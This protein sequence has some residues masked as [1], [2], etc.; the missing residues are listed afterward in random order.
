L[1]ALHVDSSATPGG[2]GT[3][4]SP[5]V[6][7]ADALATV[8]A[9]GATIALSK[10]THVG[11]VR[12]DAPVTILGACVAETTL[13]VPS[14]S[15]D[16][17]TLTVRARIALGGVTVRGPAPGIDVAGLGAHVTA[18]GLVIEGAAVYG[19]KVTDDATFEASNV[20]IRDTVADAAGTRGHGVDVDGGSIALSRCE[21]ARNT[22][23]AIYARGATTLVV[24]DALIRDTQSQPSDGLLGGAMDALGGVDARFSRTVFENNRDKN[25][26]IDGEGTRLLLEDSVVRGGLPRVA[27]DFFGFGIGVASG[28][29]ATVRRT[30]F[31][32]NRTVAVASQHPETE[33]LLEDVV[34]RDTGANPADDL[35]GTGLDLQSG[36]HVTARRVLVTRAT[37][38]GIRLTGE[39]SVLSGEDVTIVDTRPEAASREGGF[40]LGVFNGRVELTRVRMGQNRTAHV[41]AAAGGLVAFEDATIVDG[42]SQETDGL[43]GAGMMTLEGGRVT[44]RRAHLSDLKAVAL[45]STTGGDITGTDIT[46]SFVTPADCVDG[47]CRDNPGGFGAVS[48]L[49]T[50]SLSRF[51]VSDTSLC[52]LSVGEGSSLVVEDGWI[53]R[54]AIG[55]NVQNPA[56]DLE[57]IQR[58]ILFSDNEQNL[59]TAV[60]SPPSSGG[61]GL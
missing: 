19:V 11:G 43:M 42:L 21:L 34:I 58:E 29:T 1:D 8:G 41:F 20:A 61:I 23:R 2:D 15:E 53:R 37:A 17:A 5:F 56:I 51:V 25:V 18:V 35:V 46:I 16:E 49:G 36:A 13:E 33:L 6:T 9:G 26:R 44:L 38:Q 48:T 57:L 27:D 54:S 52:G 55:I 31:E 30:T 24:E 45:W 3:A 50:L 10:G 32:N 7:I 47:G 39:S 28:S 14:P 4:S 60:L 40:G 22:A 12:I 59:D